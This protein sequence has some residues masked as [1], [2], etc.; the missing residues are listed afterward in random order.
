[1]AGRDRS[2]RDDRARDDRARDDRIRGGTARRTRPAAAEARRP[3]SGRRGP[4]TGGRTA[5]VDR[6]R[7]A[8]D[9][10]VVGDVPA[11]ARVAGVLLVLAGLAGAAALFPR[12]LVVG[13]EQLT[14]GGGPGAV[15]AG[16]LVPLLSVAVGAGLAAGRVPR[17]GLAFAAV[18][19]ALA[20]GGLLLELYR[21][22]SSTVRP[23]VEVLAGEPVLTSSVETGPGWLLQVAAL[24][25][26]VLAGGCAALVWGRTRMEDRGALDPARPGLAGA[27]VLLGVLTVLCLALPAADVPDRLVA[28]PA[29]GLQVVVEQE[30]PQGLL[31]RPGLALLGGLL[32]AGAVLLVAVLAPSLRPR[33][34]AVG[35]LLAL[36]ATVLAAGLGGLRDAVASPDLE[37]TVPGAGLLAAGL[38][39][40][41]LTVLTWRLRRTVGG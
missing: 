2:V 39:Y 12:Y 18:G 38:G 40:A 23:G 26:A 32:L 5:T 4:A 31:E 37:W 7:A 21:G 29:T 25:L 36:A 24:G 15:L 27:A 9:G 1:M 8:S 20:L 35:G 19:G 22:S 33:L 3:A 10:L 41:L 30:G 14:L 13:G 6:S 16:L 28:D 11:G 34:A 17:F